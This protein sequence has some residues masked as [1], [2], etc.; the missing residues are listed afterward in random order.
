MLVRLA[1]KRPVSG[2]MFC[3]AAAPCKEKPPSRAFH[4]HHS[5]SLL[6]DGLM[7]N[8]LTGPT[9]REEAIWPDEVTRKVMVVEVETGR[10]ALL[11]KAVTGRGGETCV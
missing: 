8:L 3:S 5:A 7:R 2:R 6:P 4:L 9:S 11:I 10:S 1:E